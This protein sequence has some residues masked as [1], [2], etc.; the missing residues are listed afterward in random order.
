[1]KKKKKGERE[2]EEEENKENFVQ[3]L[4]TALQAIHTSFNIVPKMIFARTPLKGLR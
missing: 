4:C 2:G 3:N 1:M